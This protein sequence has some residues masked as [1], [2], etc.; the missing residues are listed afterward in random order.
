MAIRQKLTVTRYLLPGTYVGQ[1][2]RPKVVNVGMFPRIP[3]YIG[4]GLPYMT[5]DNMPIVRS[6]VYKEK[7]SFPT[8]GPFLSTL[9]SPSNGSQLTSYNQA[10]IRLYNQN[11]EEVPLRFW[12]F[13]K[14]TP[15][16]PYDTVEV[17][18][19]VFNPNDVYYIDYQSTSD[20]IKDILPINGIRQITVV[21]DQP[22]EALY[23]EHMDWESYTRL[24]GPLPNDSNVGSV[25][26]INMNSSA[27]YN[28]PDRN[29][30]FTVE[31]NDLTSYPTLAAS[32][33]G[34]GVFAINLAAMT[35][36]DDASTY[37]G[38]NPAN[39]TL[40]VANYTVV[41]ST[42]SFDL[43][44]FDG[45]DTGTI[46][47]S[48]TLATIPAQ[49]L[50]NGVFV[51]ITNIDNIQND[52]VLTLTVVQTHRVRISWYSDDYL[53]NTGIFDFLGN[54]NVLNQT[55]ESGITLDFLTLADFVV[56][57]KWSVV[58]NNT[59]T[60]N[61]DFTRQVSQDFTLSD[62]Y[63]DAMGLVTGTP[64][65]YYI[66]LNNTPV[67]QVLPDV[68]VSLIRIDT[69]VTISHTNIPGTPYVKLN[70]QSPLLVNFRA[71]YYFHNAPHPGQQYY[72]TAQYTRPD[73]QYNVVSIYT[74]Y[75]DAL[76]ERGYPSA[77]N[78][79]G[80][81]L[82]YAFNAAKC[83]FVAC[84][85][86]YD[87]DHD[88]VYNTADYR[89]ALQA[90]DKN[91]EITDISV[92]G[93]F[94]TLADQMYQ[95]QISNDPLIGALR[96]YWIGYPIG[97]AVGTPGTLGTIANTSNNILQVSG[98]NSAHGSFIS[99]ANDFVKRTIVLQTGKTVQ[100]TLDGSFF[101]GMLSAINAA[102]RDPNTLLN[103]Q[104]VPGIDSTRS[105]TDTQME[106]LGTSSNTF[107]NLPA[108]SN[109]VKVIDAVTTDI[110]A[111][112]YHEINV[113]CVKHLVS[114]R[115][116]RAGN[117]GV[118]NYV[119]RNVD[120]GISFVRSVIARELTSLVGDAIIADYSDANGRPRDLRPEQ[121]V[122]VWRDEDTKTRYNF[123]YWW[124][125]RYGI[126][127][128]TG[129]FSVD[130]NIFNPNA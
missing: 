41:G 105:Y 91:K 74:G 65:T 59:D 110:S 35:L 56:G 33:T 109:V 1:V 3:C 47:I 86:V 120:D 22:S 17:F 21:G 9:N 122:D 77:D 13:T 107:A 23:Q 118:I 66:T 82:D 14:I 63:Y 60:I 38:A 100:L 18:S 16:G 102:Y 29:Y 96:L 88:G 104:V 40:T 80:V 52:D 89:V 71:T 61:W 10:P 30:Y 115:I 85:Q 108:N 11:E 99:C 129:L 19:E 76:A 106:V 126:K 25:S 98:A 103:A 5:A 95:S 31:G 49:E 51:S 79:I 64:R 26:I 2:Y 90:T 73:S 68:T 114:K 116:I 87:A 34:L 128:L 125:G 54:T 53:S 36:P 67:E 130:E 83:D 45:T 119:P 55:L 92:L 15:S 50:M 48:T 93:K 78:H 94:D 62:I 57:D 43:D 20:S 39:Y 42:T 46:S 32:N 27:L 58:A 72:V 101:A 8:T 124:N 81:M 113:M 6:F 127:R 7:C 12:K 75:S 44:W 24:T 69:G 84:V 28:G 97:Y 117:A 121:D 4:K 70:I 112:D 123:T 37:T 111:D